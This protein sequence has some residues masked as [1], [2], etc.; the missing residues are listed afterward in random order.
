MPLWAQVLADLSRR[1]GAGEF[2]LRFPTDQELV[3]GY[4]VSRQTVREA[5]RRLADDGLVARERGRGTRVR[6]VEFEH[7]A[8]TLEG[9]FQQ[10]EALGV[11]QTSVVRVREETTDAGIARR[12][13]LPARARL[14]H[15]ERLR[16][17][18]GEPLALDSSWLPSRVAHR[19]LEAPLTRAGLYDELARLC[20]VKIDRGIERVRPVIPTVPERG[21]L[22]IPADVAAFAIERLVYSQESPVEW[23]HSLVRGDRYS[24]VVELSPARAQ[25]PSLPWAYESPA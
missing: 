23:R 1:L 8:G 19:L 22:D 18:D 3:D 12:L 6:P 13:E 25:Q 21:A 7:T 10:V 9:L 15:I 2:D 17:A 16:L 5:V 11:T 4:G 14:V 20:D 24:F